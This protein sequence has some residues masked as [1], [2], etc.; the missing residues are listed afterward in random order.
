MGVTWNCTRTNRA[1]MLQ[2]RQKGSRRRLQLWT[3]ALITIR[4]PPRTG[5]ILTAR[6][7]W[8]FLGGYIVG[9]VCGFRSRDLARR[10]LDL[11]FRKSWAAGLEP[12]VYLINLWGHHR[13][14]ETAQDKKR[15]ERL[16][17]NIKTCFV[18]LLPQNSPLVYLNSRCIIIALSQGLADQLL[19]SHFLVLLCT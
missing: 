11:G 5:R 16:A 8:R 14:S 13:Y 18:I 3:S 1:G 6:Y 7:G 15:Q 9:P 10:Q 17:R 4:Y 19:G 2:W 12:N